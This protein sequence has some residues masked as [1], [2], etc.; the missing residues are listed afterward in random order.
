MVKVVYRIRAT[1]AIVV[2]EFE[3]PYLARPTIM[4]LK[5]SKKCELLDYPPLD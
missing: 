5:H 1:G 2:K 4:R 3:S